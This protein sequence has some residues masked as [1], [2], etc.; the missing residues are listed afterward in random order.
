ML[1]SQGLKDQSKDEQEEKVTFVLYEV[2]VCSDSSNH[3]TAVNK[4]KH[5]TFIKKCSV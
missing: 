5:S 3:S 4:T 1:L 2:Q